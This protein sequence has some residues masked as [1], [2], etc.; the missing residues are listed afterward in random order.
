MAQLL[1]RNIGADVK[2]RIRKRAKKRGRSMEAEARAILRDAVAKEMPVQGF[3]T[4]F[5]SFFKG[6][7]LRPGEEI[8]ELKGFAIQPVD[9]SES[10][11]ARKKKAK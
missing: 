2:E 6:I 11:D 10:R 7:G 4:Q 9:F 5:S 1:I 3:G 8:P